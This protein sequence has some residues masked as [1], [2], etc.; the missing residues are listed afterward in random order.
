MDSA[1]CHWVCVSA[2]MDTMEWTAVAQVDT[3][4]YFHLLNVCSGATRSWSYS[5]LLHV[6]LCY[7]CIVGVI[8]W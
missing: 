8:G 3:L 7:T 1:T 2:V 5:L 6:C 4:H